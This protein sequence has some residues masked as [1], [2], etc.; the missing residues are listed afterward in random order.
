M[1]RFFPLCHE[2]GIS[3]T[4]RHIIETTTYL[5]DDL[6]ISS[7]AIQEMSHTISLRLEKGKS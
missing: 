6:S 7:E 5:D 4:V 3:F 1:H 2:V